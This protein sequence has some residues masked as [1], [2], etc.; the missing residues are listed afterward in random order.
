MV[1]AVESVSTLQFGLESSPGTLIAADVL[2]PF[3]SASYIPMIER[4]LL[5]ETRG[6]LA[7]VDDLD[8]RKGSELS[9]EMNLDYENVLLPLLTGLHNVTP[10]GVGPY[11][12][13]IDPSYTSPE[14]LAA[15]TYEMMMG[16]GSTTVYEREFG[17]G[18]CSG[19][20]INIAF[21]QPAKLTFDI[22]GRAEQMSTLT[23]S[24]A[25]L[26]RQVIVSDLFG[27]YV[28]SSWAN[29]GNTKLSTLIRSA[30]LSIVT[31]A[32]PGYTLDARDD[33]DFT[34]LRR[35]RITGT[36]DVL[37]DY[38]GDA[39]AEIA[40]WRTGTQ[41]FIQLLAG[42]G[43]RI[44]QIDLAAKSIEP[45]TIFQSDGETGT[46]GM[47]FELRY[48]TVASKLLNITVTNSLASF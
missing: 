28:D 41:V 29:L 19:F 46:V 27:F 17:Y 12:Y 16:D 33:L 7:H 1:T 20:G 15:A 11:E 14:A 42:S 44:L 9:V 13:V 22:F 30:N 45:P 21:G 31:G 18:T 48:D 32:A 47:K 39:Q 4:Q 40:N 10:T 34:V 38:T 3:A 26:A 23:A 6:L 35:G 43:D 2:L 5:E 36:L 25:V 37:F 8:V 24:Q